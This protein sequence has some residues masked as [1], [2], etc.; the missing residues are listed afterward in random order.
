MKYFAKLRMLVLAMAGSLWATAAQAAPVDGEKLVTGLGEEIC[1]LHTEGIEAR[2]RRD[3]AGA[4]LAWHLA[5]RM[6]RVAIKA[7]AAEAIRPVAGECLAESFM[8][9]AQAIVDQA[10]AKLGKHGTMKAYVDALTEYVRTTQEASQHLVE[11]EEASNGAGRAKASVTRAQLAL[12]WAELL[13]GTPPPAGFQTAE[14]KSQ[15]TEQLTEKAR[16]HRNTAVNLMARVALEHKQAGSTAGPA[17]AW[18]QQALT[19]LAKHAPD[20]LATVQA[21]TFQPLP[22]S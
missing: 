10:N 19:W 3:V 4:H 5:I 2:A 21:G 6:S 18:S 7:G 13:V 17:A 16:P 15:W 1:R 12:R 14:L 20:V 8:Q 9:L 22:E 11:A